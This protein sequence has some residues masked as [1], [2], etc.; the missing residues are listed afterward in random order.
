ARR[1]RGTQARA[2]QPRY[3]R[4]GPSLDRR[5]PPGPADAGRLTTVITFFRCRASL[6][7]RSAARWPSAGDRFVD[8]CFDG[9]QERIEIPAALMPYAFDEERWGP[10]HAAAHGQRQRSEPCAA[11]ALLCRV[12]LI[13]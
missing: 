10:V 8:R 6:A 12:D 1:R 13:G 5:P 9:L 3:G 2:Q 4:A 7:P 11:P